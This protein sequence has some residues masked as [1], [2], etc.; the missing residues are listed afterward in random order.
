MTS[1][2]KG[3]EIPKVWI[4]GEFVNWKDSCVHAF[5]FSLH[6]GVAAFEGIRFY[7]TKK[8]PA[9]FR[10]RDHVKRLVYSAETISLKSKYSENQIVDHIKLAVKESKFKS[11]YIRPIICYKTSDL[12]THALKGDVETIIGV[13][14][15]GS[16]LGKK[17]LRLM[18]SGFA[19]NHPKSVPMDAKLSGCY[20]NSILAVRE[21]MKNGFDEALMLDFNGNVAEGTAENF[22]MVKNNVLITPPKDNILAGFTRDCIIRIAKDLKIKV[23]EKFFSGDFAKS[24][25]EAF[26]S[27]TAAEITPIKSINEKKIT[28]NPPGRITKMI[29]DAYSEILAGKS[30]K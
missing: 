6:Y 9:V 18:I 14:P 25:D 5:S 22:F 28:K 4:D 1:Q 2:S 15:W 10:L 20:V 7:E 13:F 27:G 29:S 3:S 19:R 21:A 26:Y 23:Q 8:G 11:G 17:S 16:Y 24:A 12:Q 30:N